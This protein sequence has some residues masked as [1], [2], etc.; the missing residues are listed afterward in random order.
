MVIKPE[1]RSGHPHSPWA[2][3]APSWKEHWPQDPFS[4]IQQHEDET[5]PH[6]LQGLLPSCLPA[7]YVR[8]STHVGRSLVCN[9]QPT[10]LGFSGPNT[11]DLT[12]TWSLCR[13][14]FMPSHAHRS[15]QGKA[16]IIIQHQTTKSKNQIQCLHHITRKRW[17][18][19]IID[20]SFAEIEF[21]KIKL[22]SIDF[23]QQQKF[24]GSS[25]ALNVK[26]SGR[27]NLS[28]SVLLE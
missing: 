10:A 18:I 16:N 12:A 11:I 17:Q 24:N 13:L 2:S 1:F 3:L 4:C 20:S 14:F 15:C 7:F 27:L 19:E 6:Y 28:P 22:K 23:A 21:V 8:A 5:S 9:A 25:K 26:P